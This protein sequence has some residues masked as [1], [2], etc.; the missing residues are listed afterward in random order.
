MWAW[1]AEV[2]A[3]RRVLEEAVQYLNMAED[4]LNHFT[5]AVKAK[6]LYPSNPIGPKEIHLLPHF[7]VHHKQL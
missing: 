5:R 4:H 3:R 2:T 6:G 1:E 7:V